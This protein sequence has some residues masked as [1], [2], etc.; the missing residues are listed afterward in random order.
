MTLQP[1]TLNSLIALL[2]ER[3]AILREEIA[4]LD[5]EL[6]HLAMNAFAERWLE[7]QELL[8]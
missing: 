7:D 5:A 2:R 4:Q 1:I 6:E 3:R 8:R